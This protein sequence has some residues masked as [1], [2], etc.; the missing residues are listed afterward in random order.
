MLK[1]LMEIGIVFSYNWC[2][3]PVG[4]NHSWIPHDTSYNVNGYYTVLVREY[5]DKKMSLKV[6]MHF[7]QHFDPWLVES[8]D[9]EFADAGS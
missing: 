2:N 4:W 5:N 7:P 3:P 1:F 9:A 8:I 6:Q